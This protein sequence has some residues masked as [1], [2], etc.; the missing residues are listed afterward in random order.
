MC[1]TTTTPSPSPSPSTAISVV[2]LAWSGRFAVGNIRLRGGL[3]SLADTHRRPAP[4]GARLPARPS[5]PPSLFPS[6][7]PLPSPGPLHH[8][9]PPQP[10]WGGNS[11][12]RPGAVASTL[13]AYYALLCLIQGLPALAVLV[14][15]LVVLNKSILWID[16]N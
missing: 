7:V 1:Y 4:G 3:V 11:G 5:V 8:H 15:R 6:S 14:D 10:S 9:P 2:L 13:Y 16:L 12:G